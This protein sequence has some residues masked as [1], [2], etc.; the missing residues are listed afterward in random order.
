MHSRDPYVPETNTVLK[1]IL[2]YILF[3]GITDIRILFHFHYKK[4]KSLFKCEE[5]YTYGNICG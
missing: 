2:K 4:N 1:D 3:E 5:S